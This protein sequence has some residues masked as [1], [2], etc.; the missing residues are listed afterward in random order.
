MATIL[1]RGE[2]VIDDSTNFTREQRDRVRQVAEPYH[3]RTLVI[4]VDIPVSEVRR[5]WQANRRTRIRAD[6]R[7]ADF[8]QVLEHFAPPTVDEHVL[9]YEGTIPVQD[10]VH[11][12]FP[13]QKADTN[14]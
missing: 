8:A 6:V 12:T 11:L 13:M 4:F 2:S 7:D 10:W 14:G 5:R 3:A 9:R 1:S